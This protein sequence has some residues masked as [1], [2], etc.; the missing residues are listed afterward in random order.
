MTYLDR[1]AR[2]EGGAVTV[3]WVVLTG[4]LV[5]MGMLVVNSIAGGVGDLSTGVG[6]TLAGAEVAS[7]SFD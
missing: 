2:D 4:A 5:T 7:L 3:D 1:F 6:A